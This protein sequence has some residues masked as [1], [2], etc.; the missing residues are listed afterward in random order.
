MHVFQHTTNINFAMCPNL[1]LVYFQ[2]GTFSI[3][4]ADRLLLF[5]NSYSLGAGI[6]K[7]D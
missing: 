2:P 4:E 5:A 7:G 3:S 6:T 1:Y